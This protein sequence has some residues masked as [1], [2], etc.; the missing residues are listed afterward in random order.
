MNISRTQE[1]PKNNGLY[2]SDGPHF[3]TVAQRNGKHVS[4]FQVEQ[5]FSSILNVITVLVI[6]NRCNIVELKLQ[7]CLSVR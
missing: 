3:G 4:G 2:I 1:V 6:K 7:S 5:L